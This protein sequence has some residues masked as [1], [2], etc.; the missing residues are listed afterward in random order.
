MEVWKMNSFSKGWFS[1]SILVFGGVTT[2]TTTQQ[3]ARLLSSQLSSPVN[4]NNPWTLTAKPAACPGSVVGC[5]SPTAPHAIFIGLPLFGVSFWGTSEGQ[6]TRFLVVKLMKPPKLSLNIFKKLVCCFCFI[7]EVPKSK[8]W[9]GNTKQ[10]AVLYDRKKNTSKKKGN[11]LPPSLFE[12]E[13]IP[14]SLPIPTRSL[15]K[16]EA[17]KSGERYQAVVLQV[18][19]SKET[20]LAP[21]KPSSERLQ[22]KILHQLTGFDEFIPIRKS[23]HHY[24]SSTSSWCKNSTSDMFIP[25]ISPLGCENSS[26]GSPRGRADFLV[27]LFQVTKKTLPPYCWTRWLCLPPKKL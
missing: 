1:G 6:K 9:K 15:Q 3:V 25:C 5:H 10:I 18:D 13:A 21:M 19:L 27:T 8:A 17:S 2:Q 16:L 14:T 22:T 12:P 7:P 11:I 24:P 4:K 20:T 23:F 26:P